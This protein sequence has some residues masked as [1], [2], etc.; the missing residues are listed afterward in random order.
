MQSLVFFHDAPLILCIN[1]CFQSTFDHPLV[2]NGF[3]S[4]TSGQFASDEKSSEASRSSP[5]PV[6][7]AIET[8]TEVEESGIPRKNWKWSSLALFLCCAAGNSEVMSSSQ[9]RLI[10]SC[11]TAS[12][13]LKVSPALRAM[14]IF[15][16]CCVM[17]QLNTDW[18]PNM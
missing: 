11:Q 7:S 9:S 1:A 3:D 12:V 5:T 13:A 4:P 6:S 15:L 16:R 8:G 14:L 2:P 17:V 10:G 18:T